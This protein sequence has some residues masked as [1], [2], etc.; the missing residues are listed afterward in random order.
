MNR[1]QGALLLE[2][3]DASIAFHMTRRPEVREA[4]KKA[5]EAFVESLRPVEEAPKEP[6][7][8]ENGLWY[9]A[10]VS[11]EDPTLE[12][13]RAVGIVNLSY[14]ESKTGKFI[15]QYRGPRL[16]GATAVQP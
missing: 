2:A 11:N 4:R 10:V 8:G 9:M 12:A 7:L 15:V 16:D 14:Y 1:R 13:V 6:P 3:I 5:A